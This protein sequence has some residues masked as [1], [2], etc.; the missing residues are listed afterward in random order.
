MTIRIPEDSI[1]SICEQLACLAGGE[2]RKNPGYTIYKSGLSMFYS[3]YVITDDPDENAGVIADNILA[4]VA[5]GGPRLVSWTEEVAGP[6]FG[7]ELKRRG[8]V[9]MINQTGMYLDLSDWSPS[10]ADD[11]NI[12]LIG[13][14]DLEEWSRAC[15]VGFGKPSELPALQYFIKD[16]QCRF[17][18]C[19]KD[20]KIVGTGL[21]YTRDGNCGIHEVA[22]LPDYR[23]QGVCSALISR[24]FDDAKR[25]GDDVVSLQAS[26]AGEKVYAKLG[27]KAVSR[28]PGW[29]LF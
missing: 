24:I 17:Y 9:R 23:G 7:E 20:G 26:E 15:E 13:E 2:I 1:V 16:S 8:F 3:R 12:V 25:G 4:D 19:K 18:A 11:Q 22:T 5:A 27:M 28:M 6:R 21:T 29:M 10:S 14:N